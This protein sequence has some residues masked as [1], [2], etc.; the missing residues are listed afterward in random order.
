M[1]PAFAKSFA[2]E[3]LTPDGSVLREDVSSVQFP[4]RDGQVGIL[5]DRAP[6][7]AII[8]A[9]R[10]STVLVS[11]QKRTFFVSGGF[12]QVRETGMTI[13][14]E[15]CTPVEKLDAE[16]LWAQLQ[17]VRKLPADTDQQYAYRNELIAEAQMR[18]KLAMART[19]EGL[20]RAHAEEVASS[21]TEDSP[22]E[23]E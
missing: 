22:S 12:A 3:I 11:G 17:E 2:L 14:A 5:P 21:R 7:I 20:R 10:L 9:G 1:S 13:L 6:L 18:F 23:S 16:Q 4:A 15:E 8:G 19:P